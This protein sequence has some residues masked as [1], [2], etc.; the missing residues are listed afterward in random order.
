M[1]Q[2]NIAL[3]AGA[4]SGLRFSKSSLLR[5]AGLLLFPVVFAVLIYAVDIFLIQMTLK[6]SLPRGDLLFIEGLVLVVFGSFVLVAGE[7]RASSA[8]LRQRLLT[9]VPAIR[10]RTVFPRDIVR[11]AFLIIVTGSILI[12]LSLL[13]A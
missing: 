8:G 6:L 12:L 13:G 4:L 10:L 11:I 1:K 2:K 9:G 5:L 7:N 3:R